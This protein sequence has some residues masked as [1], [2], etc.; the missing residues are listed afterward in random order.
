MQ[1]RGT[2]APRLVRLRR[3]LQPYCCLCCAQSRFLDVQ[4]A[5]AGAATPMKASIATTFNFEQVCA[6]TRRCEEQM[7]NAR[8]HV[9][10][11]RA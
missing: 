9:R 5:P 7:P 4:E 3:L 11:C 8:A 2:R 1:H 10:R 6:C